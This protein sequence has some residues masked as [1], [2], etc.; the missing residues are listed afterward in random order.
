VQNTVCLPYPSIPG[1]QLMRSLV[2]QIGHEFLMAG[3][4]IVDLGCSTGL[5]LEPFVRY[6]GPTCD[7]LGVDTS[8]EM[9]AA[10]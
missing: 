2:T 10:A 9:V 1:Y 7:Y 4:R 5:G 8:P 3:S 6:W